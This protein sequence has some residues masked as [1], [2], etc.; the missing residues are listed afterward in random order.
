[1]KTDPPSIYLRS[2]LCSAR[3]RNAAKFTVLQPIGVALQ[4]DDLGVMHEPIDPGGG[5]DVVTENLAP[6]TEGLVARD[7]QARSLVAGGDELGEKGLRPRVA[8]GVTDPIHH[9][10]LVRAQP[11]RF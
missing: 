10:P 7:D 1:M 6:P 4:R 5:G 11:P 3:R 2:L 9:P 8:R